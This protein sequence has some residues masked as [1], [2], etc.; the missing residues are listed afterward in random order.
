MEQFV[1]PDDELYILGD[2]FE[3]WIG[4]DDTNPVADIVIEKLSAHPGPKFLMHG[5]RDFL[6]G[7]SF[8]D[9]VNATLLD[10]PYSMLLQNQECVLLH[11]DSLC[12]DDIEYQQ[13]KAMVRNPQWQ[14]E[15]LA[16]PLAERRAIAQGMRDQ[17]K[18]STQMKAEDITDVSSQAVEELFRTTGAEII[19]H[20]HTHRQY[21]H[22]LEVDGQQKQRIVLGDW[23][24]TASVLVV[25]NNLMEL[26]NYSLQ[27][28]TT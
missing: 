23:G 6:L 13:F 17:S 4:D 19:L 1:Q 8:A 9:Q 25:N 18:E 11:G 27:D 10:E 22:F 26:Q 24:D 7:H 3:V 14:A 5:N 12:T 15:F 20:G 16:R 21:H 2:F 28:L